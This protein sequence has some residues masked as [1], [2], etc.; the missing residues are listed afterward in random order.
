[1][2]ENE[3]MNFTNG[4]HFLFA[5]LVLSHR[6]ERAEMLSNAEFV[7]ARARLYPAGGARWIEV[8]GA[9]AMY[10]GVKSPATQTFGLGLFQPVTRA[11]MEMIEEFYAERKA[12]VFHEVS[13]L[14][15]PSALALLNERGYQP[16]EFTSVMFRPIHRELRLSGSEK[17]RV[18]LAGENEQD[19]WAETAAKGWSEFTKFAEVMEELMQVTAKRS[20]ALS[21]LAEID[22]RAAAAGAMMIHDCVAL[23]AGASTIPRYRRQ[24][25]QLALLDSRLRYAA[26]QGCDLAM[27]CALP[28]SGSQR[29]AER[30]GFRIAYTRIK[31]QLNRN[32]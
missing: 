5:D 6:L 21:F 17:V 30:H 27:M 19:L 22:G 26:G 29:N 14:A 8:A 12:P 25:A 28:G 16:V 32:A 1:M 10:D 4:E 20:G 24:G 13:P 2:K 15:D 11:D 31:W 9:Y 23:L 18:R 3:N 7:E